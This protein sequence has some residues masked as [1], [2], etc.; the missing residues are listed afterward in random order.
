[1]CKTKPIARSGA[2]RRCLDCR[3]RISDWPRTSGGAPDCAKRTQFHRSTRGPGGRNAQNEPNLPAGGIPHYFTIPSFQGSHPTPILQNEPNFGVNRA[4][5]SQSGDPGRGLGRS[6]MQNEPNFA[7]SAGWMQGP[8]VQTN[9]IPGAC[10]SGDRRSQ[11]PCRAKCAKRTQFSAAK[12]P[13]HSHIPL[14]QYSRPMLIMRNEAN[15]PPS[16][17]RIRHRPSAAIALPLSGQ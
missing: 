11:G 14:F 2:P 10:R 3:L 7:A 9:P 1:M 13:H 8:V 6:T 12:I 16:A 15:P 5:R 4:K 17:G